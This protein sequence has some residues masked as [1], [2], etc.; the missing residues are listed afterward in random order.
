MSS[1]L[2]SQLVSRLQDWVVYVL[3][4]MTLT[5]GRRPDSTSELGVNMR[6]LYTC[7]KA[8]II[9]V[10]IVIKINPSLHDSNSDKTAGDG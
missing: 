7:E 5:L 4:H 10:V 2:P 8:Q 9:F 6:T 1:T 3:V